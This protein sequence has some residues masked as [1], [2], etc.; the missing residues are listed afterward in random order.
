MRKTTKKYA[1]LIVTVESEHNSET[2]V[3]IKVFDTRTQ[4]FWTT[5]QIK[6]RGIER[7]LNIEDMKESL[8]WNLYGNSS[9]YGF[10]WT[11]SDKKKSTGIAYICD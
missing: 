8:N 2:I 1:K 3:T 9:H 6:E 10:E 7:F 5:D 4:S 11:N